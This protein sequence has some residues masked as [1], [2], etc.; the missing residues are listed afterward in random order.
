MRFFST[1]A[2]D[3]YPFVCF[4]AEGTGARHFKT[5]FRAAATSR[6]PRTRYRAH[7]SPYR[8]G[9]TV[10][11]DA[12]LRSRRREADFRAA[13][14]ATSSRQNKKR[15]LAYCQGAWLRKRIDKSTL[16]IWLSAA[17]CYKFTNEMA[18]Q[19]AFCSLVY[20]T[21]NGSPL[22]FIRER[23][24][25]MRPVFKPYENILPSVWAFYR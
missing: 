19:I 13:R 12:L 9:S 2:N 18:G 4:A 17:C 7:R 25:A 5:T 22:M 16:P 14:F 21:N 8:A 6:E 11:L 10:H 20:I 15:S 1:H 3:S 24:F 23:E